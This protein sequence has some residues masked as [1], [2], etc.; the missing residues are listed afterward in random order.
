MI[1]QSAS[2]CIYFKLSILK[3][4]IMGGLNFDW[5]SPVNFSSLEL[6]QSTSEIANT[7]YAVY[8]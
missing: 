2:Y 3:L 4:A 8:Y 6:Q 7:P 1:N 5:L